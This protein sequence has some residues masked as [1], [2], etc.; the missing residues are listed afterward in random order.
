M[1][2]SSNKNQGI[3]PRLS[4]SKKQEHQTLQQALQIVY[5]EKNHRQAAQAQQNY[6]KFVNYL[7]ARKNVRI[8]RSRTI[9]QYSLQFK[10]GMKL[11]H[12][13]RLS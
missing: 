9:M 11:F 10:T 1:I 12:F 13:I 4:A 8:I 3:I 2:S 7:L 6:C 5:K